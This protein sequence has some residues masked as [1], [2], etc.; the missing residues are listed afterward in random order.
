MDGRKNDN[1]GTGGFKTEME[2]TEYK[3]TIEKIW[4]F[5]M[6]LSV[7]QYIDNM[8]KTEYKNVKDADKL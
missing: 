1:K 5:I 3:L 6:I 7:Q 4:I 8:W 2:K